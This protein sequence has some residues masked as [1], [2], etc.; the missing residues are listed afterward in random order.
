MDNE[1]KFDYYL[2]NKRLSEASRIA[3]IKQINTFLLWVEGQ[4]IPDVT[5]VTYNDVMAF[6]KQCGKDGNAQKTVA[7][8][9]GFL[10]HYFMWLIKENEIRENPVSNIV[11]Q[12]V[13]RKKLHNILKREQL[14]RLYNDLD[15]SAAPA[16]RNKCILGVIVFQA[17]RVDEITKL[18]IKDVNLKEGKIQIAG[19]RKT[20]G[21][22]LKL[23][24]H[25]I[26]D[27]LEY[28]A[29]ARKELL[30]STGKTTDSLFISSG[31]GTQLLNT[32]QF[33]L[34]QIKKQDSQVKDWKQLRA[35]VISHWIT[36]YDLRRAQYFAG[37][38][39]ISSTEEY[40]QQD[41]DELLA[42]VNQFH[43]L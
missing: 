34:A 21:R 22:S 17:L 3:I 41:L 19:G 15:A 8:K 35:S 27:L 28:M 5:E 31:S 33:I 16:I 10:N 4:S 29:G 23:E 6:V 18:T 42:D 12:G 13:K 43:P 24:A 36:L 38:R 30:E 2:M 37:H 25:Q 1:M 40:K 11:I 7:L 39:F 9:L 20:K 14:D 32:L 26:V